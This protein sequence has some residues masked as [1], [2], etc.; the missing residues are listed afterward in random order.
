MDLILE[1]E[2]YGLWFWRK[3][4]AAQGQMSEKPHHCRN[5]VEGGQTMSAK[6]ITTAFAVN[7]KCTHF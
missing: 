5:R 2:L 6:E 3:R 7:E 4:E 1:Y